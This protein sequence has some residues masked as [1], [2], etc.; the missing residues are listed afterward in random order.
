MK[1]K[2]L[3]VVGLDYPAIINKVYREPLPT[4]SWHPSVP[5]SR[6]GRH[7]G[8]KHENGT[9]ELNEAMALYRVV[10]GNFN[11]FY[12]KNLFLILNM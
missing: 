4:D 8:E 10:S 6:G 5:S 1:K 12:E 7:R 9:D 2:F 11:D 3:E